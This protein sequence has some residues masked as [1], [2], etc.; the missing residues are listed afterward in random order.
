M[1]AKLREPLISQRGM[2]FLAD[3]GYDA[4]EAAIR[5]N[6][7]TAHDPNGA[8]ATRDDS[9]NYLGIPYMRGLEEAYVQFRD[10]RPGIPHKDRYRSPTG[11]RPAIFNVDAIDDP[12]LDGKALTICEGALDAIALMQTGAQRVI[13]L[14]GTEFAGL[15]EDAVDDFEDVQQIILAGDDDDAG[16]KMN[17]TLAAILSPARCKL[18]KHPSGCNDVNDVLLKHGKAELLAALRGARF[19]KVRG[20]YSPREAPKRPPLEVLK[21]SAFGADFFSHIGICKRQLSIWTGVPGDGKSTL[22]KAFIWGLMREHGIRPAAAF[23]EEDFDPSTITDMGSL[24]LGRAFAEADRDEVL[25]WMHPEGQTPRWSVI[26]NPEEEEPYTVASF[27]DQAR[28]MVTQNGADFV[29]ADPWSEFSV[30]DS[31]FPETE[32]IRRGIIALRNFAR[33]FN[34]HVAVVAHPKKHGDYG[35]TAKIADGNDIAGSLHFNGRCDLGVTVAR[36]SVVDNVTNVLVWKVRRK[37]MGKRGK[38]SLLFDE[39]TGRYS[40]MSKEELAFARGEDNVIDLNNSK[41]KRRRQAQANR[42]YW[43]D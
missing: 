43:Q 11:S 8:R 32:M 26:E 41:Q 35:G 15:I 38:F 5:F 14:P 30:A 20:T 21:V 6:L 2:K 27:I 39:V 24:H 37:V 3:R 22:I 4:A 1:P 28:A 10:M 17:D 12:G 33:D 18:F 29:L 19:M 13:A 9:A 34:V 23:F 42:P 25:N 36:D 31:R 16:R 7:F 40:P